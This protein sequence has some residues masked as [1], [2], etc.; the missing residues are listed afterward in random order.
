MKNCE[1]K[2]LKDQN[3]QGIKLQADRFV[4]QNNKVLYYYNIK[5]YNSLKSFRNVMQFRIFISGF[6]S[7]YDLVCLKL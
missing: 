2:I 4:V 6:D 5:D 7:G 3:K 1:E